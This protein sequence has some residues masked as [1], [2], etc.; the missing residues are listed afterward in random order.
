[1]QQFA[2]SALLRHP[3]TT[4]SGE[5]RYADAVLLDDALAKLKKPSN[6]CWERGD[7]VSPQTLL[8]VYPIEIQL[9]GTEGTTS[10]YVSCKQPVVAIV[11]L[12]LSP[13]LRG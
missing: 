7:A 9:A 13:F 8:E 11:I 3:L 1:M 6:L 10:F 2:A 4:A 5:V 12:I